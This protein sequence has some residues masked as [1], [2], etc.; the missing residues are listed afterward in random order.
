MTDYLMDPS[1]L[2]TLSSSSGHHRDT[3]TL[4]RT[5]GY[6]AD[7][8]SLTRGHSYD[9]D[10]DRLLMA[11][12]H[13]HQLTGQHHSGVSTN[14][15]IWFDSIEYSMKLIKNWCFFFFAVVGNQRSILSRK[16][17]SWHPS[18]YGSDDELIDEDD[19]L[20]REAK[21]QRIKAEIARRRQQIE[22]N[23]RL[24][25]ELL[26]LSRL[27]EIGDVSFVFFRLFWILKKNEL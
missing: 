17:R 21:K 14:G 3:M 12:A 8:R 2:A 19:I 6:S 11:G 20:S 4:G 16:P 7:G 15:I 18:P 24:H 13:H 23:S 26:R 27:R 22:Q 1:L 10:R 25:D 9:L 5:R